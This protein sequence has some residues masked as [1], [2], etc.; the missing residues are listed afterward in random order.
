MRSIFISYRRDDSQLTCDR[1]YGYLGPIFGV[2]QVF[3]DLNDIDGGRDFR[4]A[5]EQALASCKVMVVVIG[6]TWSTIRDATG[7]RRLDNP[8]DMVRI[9]IETAFRRGIA[10]LPLLVQGATLPFPA[11]LPASIQ[12]LAYQ[13]MRQVRPDPDFA[14]DMQVVMLDIA[15]CVPIPYHGKGLRVVRNT[16][17]RTVSLVV[18]LVSLL[19]FIVALS[20]WVNLP[21]VTNLVKHWLPQISH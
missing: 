13:N 9:E 5:I 3:R 1:I 8:N 18:G 19:I 15:A 10:V 17:R 6:P 16:A 2:K 11:P 20:T 4:A 7:R 21:V 12:Q 14:R